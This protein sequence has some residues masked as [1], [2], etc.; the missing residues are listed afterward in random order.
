MQAEN[1]WYLYLIYHNFQKKHSPGRAARDRRR[2]YEYIEKKKAE[3]AAS[4]KNKESG[5]DLEELEEV[6][7]CEWTFDLLTR[8]LPRAFLR[9]SCFSKMLF[10]GV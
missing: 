4:F 2:K 8:W 9:N 5:I 1:I 7:C 3:R 6:D 10:Y